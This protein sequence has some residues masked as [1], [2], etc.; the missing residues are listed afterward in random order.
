[1]CRTLTG[2]RRRRIIYSGAHVADLDDAN[3]VHALEMI[4]LSNAL[5]HVYVIKGFT[6]R[7]P[8]MSPASMLTGHALRYL[9]AQASNF[10][11]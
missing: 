9:A 4:E 5:K 1:M 11:L 6:C 7:S 8:V 3:L 10:Q 2:H